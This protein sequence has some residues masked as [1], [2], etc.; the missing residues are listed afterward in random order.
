MVLSAATACTDRSTNTSGQLLKL[1][2]DDSATR[3]F[4]RSAAISGTTAI[5]G[6]VDVEPNLGGSAYLFDTTTGRQIAKLLPDDGA[7]GAGFGGSV[8]ISGTTAI[9]GSVDY[10][11]QFRPGSAYLFDTA[12]GRQIATLTA[13]DTATLDQFGASVA[14]SGTTAIVGDPVDDNNGVISGSAY[15]FDVSD[16]PNPNQIAKLVPVDSASGDVFGISVAISGTV[17]IVGAIGPT[18]ANVESAYLFDTITGQQ[19]V[20]L[21]PDDGTEKNLFGVS[22]A[23]SGTTAIVGAPGDQNNGITSGSA[24]LFDTTTG[25]KIAKLLPNDGEEF[26]SF[27]RSVAI[28]GTIAIVGAKND[29]DNGDFSGSAYL[30]D[31]IAGQQIAKL[32]PNDGE[33]AAQFGRT[34]AISGNVAIVGATQG[35]NINGVDSGS[36]YVFDTTRR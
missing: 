21:L 17:A 25:V 15:V 4:G 10:N 1:S 16:P 11:N 28:S 26:D 24:Y 19:I 2:A 31:A 23:I 34:V 29:D 30:F 36:A 12:T 18:D 32:L 7:V 6:A 14:I 33:P 13:D 22:V 3:E 20:K 35:K 5:V 9:V 27:G 8:A